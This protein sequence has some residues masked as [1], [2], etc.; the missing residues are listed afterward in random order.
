MVFLRALCA[1]HL[2]QDPPG[3]TIQEQVLGLL[4]TGAQHPMGLHIGSPVLLV[5]RIMLSHECPGEAG[6][7]VM[8]ITFSFCHLAGPS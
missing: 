1:A 4:Q 3:E 7:Q 8:E 2:C 6:W 5:E